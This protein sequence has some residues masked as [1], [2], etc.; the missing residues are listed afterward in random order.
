MEK[1]YFVSDAHIA[2]S[3]DPVYQKFLSF[4]D[5]VIQSKADTLVILGDL[6]E[7][8]YGSSRYI[9]KEYPKLFKSLEKLHL[10]GIKIY[11]LYGNH[12]FNFKLP[13]DYIVYGP[14]LMSSLSNGKTFY[15]Y[16]GDGLD[17]KDYKYRFLKKILRSRSFKILITV[18]PDT[19]LYKL[20]SFFSGISRDINKKHKYKVD[21]DKPYIEYAKAKL[22][23]P[24]KYD[25]VV[26]GHTHVATLASYGSED[27]PAYYINPGFFAKDGSYVVID[28]GVVSLNCWNG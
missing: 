5:Y 22:F 9:Q 11:Y 10:N 1:V 6:F 17:P 20:A 27:S 2:S 21:A 18:I 14:E 23:G 28:K 8:F 15:A 16:H 19:L 24:N 3:K 12:D 13:F 4:L 7:F 25:Y 26:M